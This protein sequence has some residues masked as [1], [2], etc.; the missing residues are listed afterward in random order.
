MGCPCCCLGSCGWC[1]GGFVGLASLR[2]HTG[3]IG[4]ELRGL[5]SGC[6]MLGCARQIC[7]AAA[8]KGEK[9]IARDV[10]G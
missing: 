6:S 9:L 3:L 10:M 2:R 5:V 8:H 1:G 7:V 4:G